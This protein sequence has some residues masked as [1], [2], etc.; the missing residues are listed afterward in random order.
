LVALAGKFK[1]V[2]ACGFVFGIGYILLNFVL[3]SS[4]SSGSGGALA[5]ALALALGTG[6]GFSNI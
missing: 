6:R 5:L 2:N 4:G 3:S 1:T